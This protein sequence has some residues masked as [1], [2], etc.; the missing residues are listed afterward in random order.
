MAKLYFEFISVT[1]ISQSLVDQSV[2]SGLTSN[3]Q[4]ISVISG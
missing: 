3:N 2:K 1:L 4:P